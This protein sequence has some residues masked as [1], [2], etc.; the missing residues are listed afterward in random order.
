MRIKEN[1][2]RDS[3]FD[4]ARELKKLLSMRVMVIPIVI[5]GLVKGVEDLERRKQVENIQTTALIRSDRILVRFLDTWDSSEKPLTNA[6]VTN[7]KTSKMIICQQRKL[8]KD[9][10][11]L[12]IVSMPQLRGAK[13][14]QKSAKKDLF[15]A[16]NNSNFSVRA[17]MKTTKSRKE[18]WT[19]K[20][21]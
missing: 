18:K 13:N 5:D 17:K 3:Y 10:P 2:K 16:A 1:E 6:G 19:E 7:S 9:W 12:K 20:R 8:E 11:T 15:V 14:I 21:P 4:L